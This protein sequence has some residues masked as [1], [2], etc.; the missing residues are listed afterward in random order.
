[1]T[2]GTRPFT[3]LSSGREREHPRLGRIGDATMP[4][5]HRVTGAARSSGAGAANV[6]RALQRLSDPTLRG[7]AAT[8]MGVGAGFYLAG[9]SR[10]IVALGVLPAVLAVVALLARP[11]TR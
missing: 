11:T 7:V 4:F 9:K 2:A 1:M 3:I 10:G 8:S 5:V 6:E